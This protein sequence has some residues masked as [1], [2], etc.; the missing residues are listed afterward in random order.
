MPKF[1]PKCGKSLKPQAKFCAS[2]GTTMKSSVPKPRP[3]ASPPP[4]PPPKSSGCGTGCFIGC[5]IVVV[6]FIL[7]IGLLVLGGYLFIRSIKNG[8]EPGEYFSVERSDNAVECEDSLNCLENNFKKCN[9]ATGEADLGDF[10]VAD[11]EVV[12][13]KG[14]SCV[15]Y[16]KITEL[17]DLPEG[18]GWI[19]D[20]ILDS[21]M[22]DLSME[23]LIP[24]SVYG[25][26]VEGFMDYIGENMKD[27]CKGPL[28]D[29]ADRF[30]IELEN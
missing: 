14:N 20:F 11:F 2:C 3:V 30:G 22:K 29:I 1:C 24:S 23:C 21:V 18:A 19:P 5:L 26:G 27:A 6:V 15:V 9:P 7:I 17:K 12:G 25:K 8:K 28:F 16:F 4:P 13:P 10:A